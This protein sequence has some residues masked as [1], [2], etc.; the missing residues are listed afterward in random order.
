MFIDTDWKSEW[1]HQFQVRT[2]SPVAFSIRNPNQ[3]RSH[4]QLRLLEL[5]IVP[6]ST[7]HLAVLPG[8]IGN[9]PKGRKLIHLT[10]DPVWCITSSRRFRWCQCLH[11]EW[12]VGLD[13]C[14]FET[15]KVDAPS[16]SFY[17]RIVILHSPASKCAATPITISFA[18]AIWA[19]VPTTISI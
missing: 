8:P 13:W 9:G 18:P 11:V 5:H 3:L 14:L 10:T 4:L 12:W 16:P 15:I 17:R 19:L 2:F 6:P 7:I 1:I